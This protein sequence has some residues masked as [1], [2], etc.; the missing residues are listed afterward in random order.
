VAVIYELY[1]WYTQQWWR[2]RSDGLQQR[3]LDPAVQPSNDRGGKKGIGTAR[4]HLRRTGNECLRRH[5]G[6]SWDY[7]TILIAFSST[8][9]SRCVSANALELINA[10][11]MQRLPEKVIPIAT[12]KMTINDVELLVAFCAKGPGAAFSVVRFDDELS[13]KHAGEDFG[14]APRRHRVGRLIAHVAVLGISLGLGADC[15]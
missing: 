6:D 5:Q 3:R 10:L 4:N 12:I 11:R 1:I 14:A 2:I 15:T 9:L 13:A 7:N 8:W